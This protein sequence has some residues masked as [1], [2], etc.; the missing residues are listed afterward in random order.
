MSVLANVESQRLLCLEPT[1][2]ELTD[3]LVVA[4][5]ALSASVLSR[6]LLKSRLWL[7]FK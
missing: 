7:L 5:D 3:Q 6:L 2:E 4:V 1:W